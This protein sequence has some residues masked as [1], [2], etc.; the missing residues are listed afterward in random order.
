MTNYEFRKELK[1]EAL[2]EGYLTEDN[3]KNPPDDTTK[4]IFKF[5]GTLKGQIKVKESAYTLQELYDKLPDIIRKK[6]KEVY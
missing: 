1:E 3:D 6:K 2:L 4:R 5:E